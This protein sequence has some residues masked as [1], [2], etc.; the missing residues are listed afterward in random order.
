MGRW[1]PRP[2]EPA[3]GVANRSFVSEI[4][5]DDTRSEVLATTTTT[6]KA[7]DTADGSG[8][9]AAIDQSAAAHPQ[10][11]RPEF[12]RDVDAGGYGSK[13]AARPQLQPHGVTNRG[14][15]AVVAPTRS[16]WWW[17]GEFSDG[18]APPVSISYS[19]PLCRGKDEEH[20]RRTVSMGPAATQQGLAGAEA[21][22]LLRAEAQRRRRRTSSSGFRLPRV[23]APS[24]ERRSS[25]SPRRWAPS[26]VCP[27]GSDPL[28]RLAGDAT[29]E[30]L[31]DADAMR[32]TR[33]RH[34][35]PELK[36]H[37]ASEPLVQA[38]STAATALLP[39]GARPTSHACV[40]PRPYTRLLASPC[41]CRR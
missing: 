31:V 18:S 38:T 28:R 14:A 10:A 20:R 5:L 2:R 16:T 21:S 37:L 24:P 26:P 6:T 4:L 15:G 7:P 12:L 32:P 35:S 40:C 34:S 33:S 39:G 25:V 1:S 23:T 30:L 3:E 22:A 27:A 13:P 11:H 9:G 41:C 19:L 36:W 29:R 8:E 17:K